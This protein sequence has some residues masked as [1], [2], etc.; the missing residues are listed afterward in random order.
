MSE[1]C[2]IPAQRTTDDQMRRLPK[3]ARTIAVMG[4]SAD[5]EKDSHRAALYLQEHGH[6]IIPVNPGATE[7]LGEKAFTSLLDIPPD[8]AIDIVD[9]SRKPS[10]VKPVVMEAVRRGPKAMG[11][12]IGVVNNEAALFAQDKGLEVVMGVCIKGTH[13][14]LVESKQR[15]RGEVQGVRRETQIGRRCRNTLPV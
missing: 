8:I 14:R 6:R 4:L 12:P 13:E 2:E 5:P 1:T 11:M 9:I 10:E 3:E 15:V 7:I